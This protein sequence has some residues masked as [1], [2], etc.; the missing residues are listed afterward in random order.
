MAIK[1][2]DTPLAATPEAKYNDSIRKKT[3]VDKEVDALIQRKR[4]LDTTENKAKLDSTI[5]DRKLRAVGF[6]KKAA[7]MGNKKANETR[8]AGSPYKEGAF[9]QVK[10]KKTGNYKKTFVFKKKP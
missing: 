8:R 1:R 10:D 5:T 4:K 7:E 2:P 6:N 3:S 9:Q